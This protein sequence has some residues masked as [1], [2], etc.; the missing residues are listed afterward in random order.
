MAAGKKFEMYWQRYLRASA[1][2]MAVLLTACGGGGG[3]SIG[4]GLYGIPPPVETT[5]PPTN[6]AVRLSGKATFDSVPNP[7]GAL[8]YGATTPK[9][10]R[11][12]VVEVLDTASEV[13]ATTST[14][15]EGGYAVSVP[16][17]T[18]IVVRVR[19][20]LLRVG[21]GANWDVSVRDNTQSNAI[22]AM[23]TPA[24]ATG[25]EDLSRDIHAPSGW[26][27]SSYSAPR[28][29]GPF[30]VLDTIYTAQAKVLSV[31]PDIAFPPLRVFWS[32]DNVP[33]RG[34]PALGQIVSTSFTAN[35]AGRSI[36]VLGKAD[37]DTDEFDDSV[38]AHEWGHYYLSAFGR[39][40]TPGGSHSP[41]DLLDRRLAFSE[42][43]GNAWSGIALG[44]RIYTDAVGSGQGVGMRIDLGRGETYAAGWYREASIHSVLWLLDQ[45]VGF[46]PINDALTGTALKNGLALT[47]MHVFTAAFDLA[48]PASAGALASLLASQ[49]I[50]AASNDPFGR[51]ETND[52]GVSVALPMYI[53]ANVGGSTSACVSNAE[54]ANNKLGSFVYLRFAVPAARNYAI[55][56]TGPAVANPDFAVY[57]GRQVAS[58]QGRGASASALVGLS[59]G[60]AILA[61]N[62]ANNSSASTCF[63]VSI[64]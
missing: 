56:V 27:G 25:Q 5:A 46:R 29:A 35:S 24:F 34:N 51:F 28:A 36:Y 42:G 14:D 17:A 41:F 2:F 40:D 3:G 52:G 11:G 13:I 26:D 1:L 15:A 60:E 37:V 38:V 33:A 16:A 9:P 48:A 59:P 22:Y 61:I 23:Q 7:D 10:V 4:A 30:A 39:D 21:D 54:G 44:R 18:S 43:W 47:S 32:V 58:R 50:S 64:Q 53:R 62:D 20:Q 31:E 12:G 55:T 57:A 19:A 63:T 45:Q 49:N 6:S 8:D